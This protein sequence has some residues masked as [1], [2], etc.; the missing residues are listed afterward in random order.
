MEKLPLKIYCSEACYIV[1]TEFLL[2]TTIIMILLSCTFNL[3]Y[4]HRPTKK[5]NG[6]QTFEISTLNDFFHIHDFLLQFVFFLIIYFH[7]SLIQFLQNVCKCACECVGCFIVCIYSISYYSNVNLI[8]VLNI[9]IFTSNLNALL[10][11][12]HS[13]K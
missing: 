7:F 5:L 3:I 2:P 6:K 13:L 4:M 9:R 1:Q 11:G 12:S 10:F 8:N